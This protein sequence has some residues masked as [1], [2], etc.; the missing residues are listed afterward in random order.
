MSKIH[1]GSRLKSLMGESGKSVSAL[2]RYMGY[3]NRQSVYD[4]YKRED[5]PLLQVMK[6][7]E[8]LN[9]TLNE[10][11]GSSFSHVLESGPSDVTQLL[12][13]MNKRFAMLESKMDLL[14]T[15]G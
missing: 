3:S 2:A 9:I 6:F 13:A 1:L 10:Y 7:C 5:I 11:L 12:N 15:R 8:F 14:I 4:I